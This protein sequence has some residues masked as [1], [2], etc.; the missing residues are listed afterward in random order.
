MDVFV[1]IDA[2]DDLGAEEGSAHGGGAPDRLGGLT[3]RGAG[4]QD[5]DGMDGLKLL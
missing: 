5:C 3:V 1:G 4:G 2:D